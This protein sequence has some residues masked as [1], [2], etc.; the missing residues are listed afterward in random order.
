MVADATVAVVATAAAG[1]TE[2]G[3]DLHIT[4]STDWTQNAG[5]EITP[6]EWLALVGEDTE[7]L[8]DPSHG[9]YSV[10]WG[11]KAWFDWF[12]GNVF[13]SDP[14]QATVGKMLEIA[15]T[16]SG[17]VQGDD[18][19]FYESTRDWRGPPGNS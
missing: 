6:E 4:R 18:G 8:P 2:L 10:R 3:Y 9:P 1:G 7:L 15:R 13:T 16:L 17:I 5:M 14:D 12:E 11:S 19:E